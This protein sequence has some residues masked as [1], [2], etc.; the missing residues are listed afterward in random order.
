MSDEND[1]RP[2][3]PSLTL[4]PRSGSVNAGVVKQ[5]FSHGR[6]KTVVVETKRVRTHAPGGGGNLAG[7]SAAEKRTTYDP[8]PATPG[9]RPPASNPGGL[10]A[11]E[12]A[13]RQRAIDAA[14]EAQERQAAQA[15]ATAE[16]DARR[17]AAEAAASAPAPAA[18]T[19]PTAPPA[20]AP[21]PAPAPT[22]APA[23]AAP[24]VA[25]APTPAPAAPVA[26]AAPTPAPVQAAAPAP[27]RPAA[28]AAQAPAAAS[29]NQT[30]T[31]EPS[32]ERRD[33]RTSTT[34]YRPPNAG[35][36]NQRAPRPD[37]NTN[38]GQRTPRPEADRAFTPR[39]PREGDARPPRDNA[40]PGETVRY[41]ALAPKPV[42]RP[43]DRPGGARPPRPGQPAAPPATAEVQRATRQ[44][45]RPGGAG[46]VIDRRPD[47]DDDRRKG[48]APGKAVSR[49]KGEPKRREGRLTIQ[50]LAGD[51]EG[52]AERMRSLASVRRA[53][54]RE[55]EKRR[56]GAAEQARV[57]REVVIPDIITVQELSNRMAV[58]GV[59]I[60]KF[61]MRQGVMLKI[62]D[63]ID[64]DT[65]ELV[66]TEFG[67]T[68]RRVSEADVE[69]GF[70]DADDHDDHREPRAPVV[71]V[72]GHVDHGKTSLLDALRA[73]DVVA[74]EAGGITQHIGAYQ[75][76]L[77]EGDRVTFLDTP[78][79]AAFSAMRARGANITDIVILVVAADDGVMPQTI[80]AIQHA[81]A[82]GVPMIVA[83]NKMDKPDAD[84]TRV[85]NELLQHEIVV[86]S[87]GGETQIVEVS[88]KTRLGLD[89]LIERIL[90]QAEVLDLKAN[91]DRT[92][93]GVVIESK[94]DKGRGA[95][96][97][98]L[99]KRGTL[100]RGDIVVAGAAWGKVRALL[101]ERDEQLTDAG[102]S[103]PVEILG[104][105]GTPD[106][107]EPFAVVESEARARELTEYRVRLKRE[108][109]AASGPMAGAS[110]ADMM[111]KLQDKRISELPLVIKGDVQG[112]VE[113][114]VGA[115]DKIGTDEVRARIIL[116]GAGA[117]SESDVMLAKGAGAP[118]LGFNV[119]AS[120]QAR[121]LAVREG[122]EIRY[123]AIIYDLID[124]IKGVLSGML[125]PIQR[126]TFLGNAKVLQAFD[127]SKVGKV[128]GCR[129]V[130]GVVRK[131]A[132][133][134]IVRENVVVLELGTLQTLKRF[135]DEV[136]EVNAGQECGM[137]FA[138]FQD[139]REGDEIEC[140]TVE[141][142]KRQLA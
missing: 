56:G 141:E 90:L 86:E 121:D 95:V 48:A 37:A 85:I 135:K 5:T 50:V 52:A 89:E 38:F 43:G 91:P 75:V 98:V 114:I 70:L 39:P 60:I 77:K 79:H 14:R 10:S 122:V 29:P 1:N 72:M 103:T 51:D 125:A 35:P 21:A 40:R 83:V 2:A 115:L 13:A 59:D 82:A 132:K 92:A 63:V 100:K 116:S 64:N 58:R 46:A 110:M 123:Y 111:A 105:D 74:G 68:V 66:A 45:P 49:T 131:G 101:N 34:T 6:S 30:R 4:K 41:S 109:A 106:P 8:R 15:R 16:E 118:L 112:S 24:V 25:Q 128:A 94:L 113:A 71:T 47:D 97:T 96:A 27:A 54:E 67:H 99:V 55:K 23:P 42:A 32:R 102:P 65:A 33:D 3:R 9:A 130:E 18:P 88:A 108:R 19:A 7:P 87:L 36:F 119:R 62:N 133:V 81:K 22:P 31:Y 12:H 104:L 138:G 117:I 17:R 127:I 139:I 84:P 78:G 76:R 69:E 20:E 53:R 134:R 137:A 120:R 28:P 107:G 57:A 80:E 126:E 129:V 44:A 124:D 142:V 93:E 73:T 136:P 61:L 26:V 11:E 140:F